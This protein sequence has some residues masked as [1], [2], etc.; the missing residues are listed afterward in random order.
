VIV[1]FTH[2]YEN[3]KMKKLISRVKRYTHKLLAHL[4]AFSLHSGTVWELENFR[5]WEKHGYHITPIHYY[6]PIP[7][8]RD[9]EQRAFL[10][11]KFFGIDLR[12]EYQLK[13]INDVFIKFSEEYNNFPVK[14]TAPTSFFLDNDAFNGIDPYPYYCL[15][16]HYKPGLVI[17]IGSGY[18]TLL[19]LQACLLNNS[20]HYVCVDPW[21]REFISDS[22]N[23]IEFIRKKVEDI[24]LSFFKQL[25]TNDI[26]FI[27]SSHVIRTQGDVCYEILEVLP[28]LSKGVIVHFHDIFLPFEYPKEWLVDKHRFW[29][30]QYLLQAYL[31][32]NSHTEILFT[33]NFMSRNY[34]EEV[35]RAFPNALWGG[36]G[37]FWFRKC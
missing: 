19:G 5:F 30:E 22:I 27:D 3:K 34:P 33:S 8:T 4:V 10:P 1:R 7:D 28:Q 12:P 36:G 18:S 14:S 23:N 9:I 16:R 21:P 29:T 37:S 17:E 35:R 6:Y 2:E 24:D 15:L 11:S 31:V 13:L 26:L 20:S 25:Q 32:E